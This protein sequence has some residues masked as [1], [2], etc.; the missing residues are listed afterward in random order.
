MEQNYILD[1]NIWLTGASSGIGLAITKALM[2]YQTNLILTARNPEKLMNS[3][4]Q[5]EGE[6]KKYAFPMNVGSSSE[7]KDAF[8]FMS[9]EV[10]FPNILINNAGIFKPKSFNETKIE[11]FDEMMNANL[12]GV[13]NTTQCVLPIMI[14]NGGG[15]I[16]NIVSVT[17]LQSFQN[18]SVYAAS[19][20]GMLAMMRGIREEVRKHNI[21][22]I[23]IIP[24]ATA[25]EI[26]DAKIVE[27]KKHL[28]ATPKDIASL[29]VSTLQLC[30]SNTSML[31]DIIIKPQN[32]DL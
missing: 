11:D 13:F 18:C 6:A 29:V 9:N 22:I 4:M 3:I 12:R 23:N 32:G 27:K 20:A 25:T 24:G 16:I 7:V 15:A 19:K 14:E 28:M 1:K 31:E 17:A 2:E 26:W 30:A 5:L 10:G 8:E 21:K